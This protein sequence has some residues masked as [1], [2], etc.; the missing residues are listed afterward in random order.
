MRNC[1]DGWEEQGESVC[2]E[3]GAGHNWALN[4]LR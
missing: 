3:Q 4:T 2:R 1:G